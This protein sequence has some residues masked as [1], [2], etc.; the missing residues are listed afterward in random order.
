M[1]DQRVE[2]L[3]ASSFLLNSLSWD[4]DSDSVGEIADT[5][6]PDELIEFGINADVL[7]VHHFLDKPFDF[8]NSSGSFVFELCAMCEFVDVDSCV[9]GNLRWSL[10]FL[11]LHH[12]HEFIIILNIQLFNIHINCYPPS[13][14]AQP[15]PS[16]SP[17]TF[18]M[19]PLSLA[20][21]AC[22]Y[23]PCT[24]KSTAS[25]SSL[26]PTLCSGVCRFGTAHTPLYIF[27]TDFLSALAEWLS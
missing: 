11:L 3:S 26:W 21:F 15:T 16:R 6:V 9:N 24:A 14:H 22:T 18:F 25:F 13:L 4:S 1:L 7:S 19:N 5:L 27:W 2:S 8:G 20:P 10:S 23:N 12:N 17:H